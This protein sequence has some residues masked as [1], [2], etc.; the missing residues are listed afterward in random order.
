MSKSLE[1]L[2]QVR[3]ISLQGRYNRHAAWILNGVVIRIAQK[4]GLHRDGEML[5]LG[6]FESE[7]RR[8]LWWQI[9]MLDAKYAMMTGLN[10]SLLPRIWDTKEPKN[11]NDSDIFPSATE[12]FQARD[13][14]TEMIFVMISNKVARFLVDTPGLEIMLMLSEWSGA[15]PTANPQLDDFRNVISRLGQ[16]LLEILNK[17]CDPSAGRVHETAV[18]VKAQIIEKLNALA[19]APKEQPE[20]GSE[21]MDSRD[22]AFKLAICAMEHEHE[23]YLAFQDKGF[24]WHALLHFQLEV[25][26]YLAGQLCNRLEGALVE[27]AWKQVDVI[28]LFHPE[29]FDTGKHKTYFMLARFILKAWSKREEMLHR[30]SGHKPETPWYIKKLLNNM[31]SEDFKSESTAPVRTGQTPLPRTQPDAL[32]PS[33]DYYLGGNFIDVASNDWDMLSGLPP[34]MQDDLPPSYFMGMNQGW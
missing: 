16:D 22:N 5:G 14:P 4:M 20:W 11:L 17:Y 3:Q 13:G 24:L 28:Y 34:S 27:R 7:M 10:H 1:T 32:D 8:R 18:Q 9:I 19:I 33:F 23:T 21:I 2:T 26:V 6:P 30:K 12:P 29:L 15:P 25:F 31:P